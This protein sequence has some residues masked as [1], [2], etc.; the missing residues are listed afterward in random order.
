ME[1]SEPTKRLLKTKFT[2][3]LNNEKRKR[4]KGKFPKQP[5]VAA[6][7]TPKL[8]DYLKQLVPAAS[9]Q[10]DKE[11]AKVQTF[12]LDA[13]APLTALLET[14][15]SGETLTVDQ[16]TAAATNALE[17]IGNANARMSRLRCEKLSGTL[18]K[19]LQPLVLRDEL[20]ED[21]APNLF[22]ATF[23]KASK[24]HIDQVKSMQAVVPRK[25]KS[26]SKGPPQ[27]QWGGGGGGNKWSGFQRYRGRGGGPKFHH[28]RGGKFHR[29]PQL[30]NKS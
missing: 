18:N 8:D 27:Q 10:A 2:V 19:S 1:V 6:M 9:K 22:G 25:P 11:L 29:P 21:A 13:V 17:L 28:D 23:A 26:F 7:K 24:D 15:G 14:C 16:V 3:S 30:G 12:T 5:K 4:A 20:F